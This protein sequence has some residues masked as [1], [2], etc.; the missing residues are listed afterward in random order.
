MRLCA[1]GSSLTSSNASTASSCAAALPPALWTPT[2]A[3]YAREHFHLDVREACL[4]D[5]AD[6]FAPASFALITLWHVLE[7]LWAPRRDL[8]II[9]TLLKPGGTL[10]VEVPNFG[11]PLRRLFG[12]SWAYVDVPRHLLQFTPRTLR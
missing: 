6:S 11:D 8:Q 5:V 9:R 10:I 12:S 7:H 2:R 3:H 4:E 1:S